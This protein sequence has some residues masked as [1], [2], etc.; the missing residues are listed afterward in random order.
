MKAF[1]IT[2][3]DTQPAVQDVPQPEP[4]P[5]EVRVEVE[6]ASVNGFDLSVAAGYVC[7]HDAA[8]VPRRPRPR[9]RRHRRRRR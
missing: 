8:P 7:G 1:G 6:A 4:A 5:G 2:A 3:R 9:P